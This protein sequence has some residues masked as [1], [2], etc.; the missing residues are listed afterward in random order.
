MPKKYTSVRLPIGIVEQIRALAKA[1][2]VSQATIVEQAIR[3]EFAEGPSAPE[4]PAVRSLSEDS[5]EIVRR[6]E[7]VE[8]MLNK[9]SKRQAEDERHRLRVSKYTNERIEHFVEWG[10]TVERALDKHSAWMKTIAKPQAKRRKGF[11]EA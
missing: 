11:G 3:R 10:K 1:S 9:V 6:L 2:G 4:P 5:S 8:K 7:E